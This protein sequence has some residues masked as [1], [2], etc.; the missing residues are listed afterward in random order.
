MANSLQEQ[1]IRAGLADEKKV[2][3]ARPKPKSTGGFKSKSS[4]KGK[5]SGAPK[6]PVQRQSAKPLSEEAAALQQERRDLRAMEQQRIREAKSAKVEA[7]DLQQRRDKLRGLLLKIGKND[8][9]GEILFNFAA[10][11]RI[12]R[13]YV[14]DSQKQ[15]LSAGELLVVVLGKRDF[16]IDRSERE[17]VR[18]IDTEAFIYDATED[19]SGT[20]D[21]EDAYADYV[22]PDDLMW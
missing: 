7:R 3:P 21:G 1:L 18:D 19:L 2:T 6:Q 17:Q 10:D 12:R 5:P 15:A 13:L 4:K 8:R 16:L 14:T 22:V 9:S 11:N 20:A